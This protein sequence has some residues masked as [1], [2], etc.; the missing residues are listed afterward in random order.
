MP[1]MVLLS[2]PLLGLSLMTV[3]AAALLVAALRF[4]QGAAAWRKI[5]RAQK[6]REVVLQQTA[7]LAQRLWEQESEHQSLKPPSLNPN[8]WVLPQDTRFPLP[9]PL[10]R[11][12]SPWGKSPAPVLPTLDLCVFISSFPSTSF[13]PL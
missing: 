11:I 3:L 12:A 5:P 4:W 13:E 1:G 7:A 10:Q 8:R 6:R 9:H 2:Y